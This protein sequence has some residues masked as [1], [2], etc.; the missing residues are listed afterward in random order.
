M[1]KTTERNEKFLL[2]E[3]NPPALVGITDQTVFGTYNSF[4]KYVLRTTLARV[5]KHDIAITPPR[6]KVVQSGAVTIIIIIKLCQM[7]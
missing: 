2:H 6:L 3:S 5:I 4:Q 1:G 7:W